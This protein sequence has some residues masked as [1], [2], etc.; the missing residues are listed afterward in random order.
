[1]RRALD[2]I[3][4]HLSKLDDSTARW[5]EIWTDPVWVLA[6][7][8]TS[9][10][11]SVVEDVEL[12]PADERPLSLRD[13][14]V[15]SSPALDC[16][17][18]QMAGQLVGRGAGEFDA[19]VRVPSLLPGSVCLRSSRD[20]PDA[21]HQVNTSAICRLSGSDRAAVLSAV[22]DEM[23]L[24]D[25]ASGKCDKGP[26]RSPAFLNELKFHD[27]LNSFREPS[28]SAA[29]SGPVAER[30]MRGAVRARVEDLRHE[31]RRRTVETERF[32]R[33]N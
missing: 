9:G 11:A 15:M 18:R 19:T 29:E 25:F 2:E 24:W 30:P 14:L 17:H 7:L 10:V 21:S 3:P 32:V 16:D 33:E 4:H 8:A 5:R 27:W 23:S 26:S 22:K 20:A 28:A 12:T 6:K 1:M 13:W 31:L